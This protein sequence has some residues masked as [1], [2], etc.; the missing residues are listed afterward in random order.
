MVFYWSCSGF[1]SSKL[2]AIIE[3]LER[4]RGVKEAEKA[5]LVACER[6]PHPIIGP[7]LAFIQE[8][9]QSSAEDYYRPQSHTKSS[10][11]LMS[12]RS[13]VLQAVLKYGVDQWFS[14]GLVVGLTGP[15][16]H[17]LTDDK[18]SPHSKLEAII[19]LLERERGV[20]EAEKALLVACER[21]PHP[22][23]GPVLAFIQEG[24]QSSAEGLMSERSRV[25]QAVL[26]YGVDQ[27][28][29]IGLAV[30]LTGPEI[31]A[32][33]DDKP[34]VSSK[35]VAIIELL[36]RER[37]VKEAEKVLLH[38]CERIP[39]RIIGVVLDII[40]EGEQSSAEDYYRPQSHTK[41]STGLMSE[42]S[43]VRT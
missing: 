8:G 6:I 27:W 5:L 12:E 29:S 7:V 22:I 41:S 31:W 42:R 36:E 37:G 17:D 30:G 15:Q 23:I 14:I 39:N 4:E 32:C 18:P 1:D 43:I 11:G 2:V 21:I 38:A 40:G 24:E 10:T 19:E 26:K 33:T 25:L 3:L 13:R 9:E 20:K 34:S 16:I 35:L 28:S